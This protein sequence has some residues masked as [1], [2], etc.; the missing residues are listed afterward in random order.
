VGVFEFYS[1]GGFRHLFYGGVARGVEGAELV[2]SEGEDVE[3][4]TV[5]GAGEGTLK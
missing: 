4:L 3:E 5:E 1:G 2:F